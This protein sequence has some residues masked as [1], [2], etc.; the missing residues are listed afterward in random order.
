ML[1]SDDLYA[2]ADWLARRLRDAG[3]PSAA[4]RL[5]HLLHDVAWTTSSELI[6]ELGRAFTAILSAHRHDLSA[7]VLQ[8]LDSAIASVRTVWPDLPEEPA[9]PCPT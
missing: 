6:G 8:A 3:L 1:D 7:E 5:S 2:R 9:R 4:D